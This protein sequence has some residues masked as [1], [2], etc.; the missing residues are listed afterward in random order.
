VHRW[1]VV[2]AA[3]HKENDVRRAEERRPR[4]SATSPHPGAEPVEQAPQFDSRRADE[5]RRLQDF[6]VQ[7][8]KTVPAACEELDGGAEV[9]S[10]GLHRSDGQPPLG[11]PRY[12]PARFRCVLELGQA[13]APPSRIQDQARW[14]M[15]TGPVAAVLHLFTGFFAGVVLP[16]VWSS[17]PARRR[18]ATAVLTQVLKAMRHRS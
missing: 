5:V 2:A 13:G 10:D 12:S 6:H 11:V 16:A 18:A 9:E 17:C 8:V 15:G 7:A 4:G 3:G 14:E 1:L